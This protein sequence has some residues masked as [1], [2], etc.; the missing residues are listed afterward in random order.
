MSSTPNPGFQ[1]D[2][3]L[4]FSVIT[5]SVSGDDLNEP[6]H[7]DLGSVPPFIAVSV[8]EKVI[9]S[10]K[11]AVPAPKITFK[12]SILMEP[13][14]YQEIDFDSFIETIFDDDEDEKGDQ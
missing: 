8:L 11:I 5:I 7:V 10:L 13:I 3:D 4:R 6:I 1:D 12:G 2:G 9:S 14:N